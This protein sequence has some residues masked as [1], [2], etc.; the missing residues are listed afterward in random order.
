[1]NCESSAVT[2]QQ[3]PRALVPRK[4]CTTSAQEIDSVSV[5]VNRV[6]RRVNEGILSADD[7]RSPIWGKLV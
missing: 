6:Y 3:C 7:T 1:M 2:N 4:P 5:G